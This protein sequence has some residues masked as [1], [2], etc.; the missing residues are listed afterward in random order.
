V[1]MTSLWRSGIIQRDAHRSMA[2][3]RAVRFA[4]P[5]SRPL[6]RSLTM[7]ATVRAIDEDVG[8]WPTFIDVSAVMLVLISLTGLLLIYFVHKHRLAGLLALTAGAMLSFGVYWLL[9]P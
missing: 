6:C 8:A 2:C 7:A 9:V 4:A 5:L 1:A 3:R